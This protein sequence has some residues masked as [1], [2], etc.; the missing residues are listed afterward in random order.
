MASTYDLINQARYL[1][2]IIEADEGVLT[3]TTEAELLNWLA[4]SE[5]KLH[6]CLAARKRIDSEA[7]LLREEEKRIAAKRKSL[8]SAS[9]RILELATGLLLER[10]TMGEE[11][12]VKTSHYTA[13]L[14]ETQSI[15]GPDDVTDWPEAWRRT[16]VEADKSAALREAKNGAKLPTGFSLVTKRSVRFR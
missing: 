3:E 11:P 16:K 6:A 15:V 1:L 10:E 13:W 12:K 7:E 14:G 8:E 4:Q 5:D 2:T 9:D